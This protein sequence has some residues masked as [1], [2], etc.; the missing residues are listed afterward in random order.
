MIIKFIKPLKIYLN[1][2]LYSFEEGSTH[3]LKEDDAMKMIDKN[4]AIKIEES[5]QE[6]AIDKAPEDKAIDKAPKNKAFTNSSNKRK[7]LKL[8]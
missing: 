4:M 8:K 1:R 2:E 3:D 5:L 6:K 7:K